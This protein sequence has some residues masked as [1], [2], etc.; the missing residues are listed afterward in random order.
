MIIFTYIRKRITQHYAVIN[1]SDNEFTE[2][3]EPFEE[4]IEEAENETKLLGPVPKSS[5]VRLW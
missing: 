5:R 4:V 1:T 2:D 3:E